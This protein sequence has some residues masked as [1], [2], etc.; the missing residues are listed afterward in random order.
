MTNEYF[1]CF[2]VLLDGNF[3]VITCL[4]P[5]GQF[6]KKTITGSHWTIR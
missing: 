4:D 1:T 5:T 2:T 6:I 3:R